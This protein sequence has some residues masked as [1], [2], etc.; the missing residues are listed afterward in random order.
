MAT[1]IKKSLIGKEDIFTSVAA[2]RT[3]SRDTSSG[4]STTLNAYAATH[5]PIFN[6]TGYFQANNVE[7]G[8][9]DIITRYFSDEHSIATTAAGLG[10]GDHFKIFG[11]IN[12]ANATDFQ[13]A[14]SNQYL[15]DGHVR[16]II[17]NGTT[18]MATPLSLPTNSKCFI[19]GNGPGSI[20][21]AS[22]TIQTSRVIS[23]AGSVGATSSSLTSQA[24]IATNTVDVTSSAN[25]SVDDWI[26]VS[27]GTYSE[28][29]RIKSIAGNT[30]TIFGQ[31]RSSIDQGAG[32]GATVVYPAE[33]HLDNL[34]I[35]LT[36][37][38]QGRGIAAT[39]L[40]NSYIGKG[41]KITGAA[42]EGILARKADQNVFDAQ[43]VEAMDSTA[44]KG[45]GVRI[46]NGN[47]NRVSG[48]SQGI[49]K[50]SSEANGANNFI[51]GAQ[52]RDGSAAS[53]M[54]TSRGEEMLFGQDAI[55]GQTINLGVTLAA[56]V[57]SI[58]GADGAALS[59]ANPG[60]VCVPSTT[61]GQN[62][63]LKVT[64][65]QSFNDD[66]H[67]SSSLASLGFGITET[68]AWAQDAPF[69]LYVINRANSNI[70][71]EDGSSVFAMA[72]NFAMNTSP[73][74]AGNIGDNATI[75]AT[76]DQTSIVVMQDVTV[77]NYTSLGTMMVGALRMQWSTV[78]DDWTV[79]A[80]SATDGIGQHAMDNAWNTDWNFPQNQNGAT[81][82]SSFL[83][84]IIE[85]TTEGYSYR[86]NRDG[87]CTI[88]IYW[89]GDGGGDGSTG[90]DAIVA[91]PYGVETT[92]ASHSLG[93]GWMNSIG[94]TNQ[95]FLAEAINAG[96]S[97]FK[98]RESGG[99]YVQFS[100]F[101][102]GGRTV[103][104]TGRFFVY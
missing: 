74:A 32:S 29:Q 6:A 8:L 43:I 24:T 18:T 95:F 46:I 69:F 22:S 52:F 19:F 14:A 49:N 48:L 100:D 66:A 26:I 7:R 2:S 62:V 104:L 101:S 50:H 30:L 12:A 68:V 51:L 90:S 72:R 70:D 25:F 37:A 20:I 60:Y 56:G 82:G 53:N 47:D 11:F 5:I 96:E 85:F 94:A 4:G 27:N 23:L 10:V 58:T 89:T 75:A 16:M 15:A 57:F 31:M 71:G 102:N 103:V 73:S 45:Y 87:S 81:A 40:V 63:T 97:R 42:N 65:P 99:G 59:S 1:T 77:A 17:P 84:D 39:Y 98:M 93:A 61:A 36:S 38:T 21:R 64:A 13:S 41:V 28:M 92:F 86:I 67:A 35:D 80:L 9:N 78:T 88:L 55:P 54:S 79:Q 34:T 33:L 3:F 83:T 91:L 76:D 44:G